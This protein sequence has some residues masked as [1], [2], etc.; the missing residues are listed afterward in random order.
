MLHTGHRSPITA[1]STGPPPTQI[2]YSGPTGRV[3]SANVNPAID[4]VGSTKNATDGHSLDSPF[5][6]L[7]LNAHPASTSLRRPHYQVHH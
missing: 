6:A 1:V 7:R 5:G 2:T 3:F 4:A